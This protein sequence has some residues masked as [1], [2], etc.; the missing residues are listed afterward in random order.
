MNDRLE[1]P[2]SYGS[3]TPVHACLSGLSSEKGLAHACAGVG[4]DRLRAARR[5]NLLGR[6][7]DALSRGDGAFPTIGLWAALGLFGILASSVMV[8]VFADQ[9]AHRRHL[10]AMADAFE[11][12]ITLPQG[13]HGQPRLRRRRPLPPTRYGFLFWL[14]LG[15]LREQVT[16]VAGVLM[17]VPT[18]ISMDPYGCGTKVL[19]VAYIAMNALVMRKTKAGQA[20]VERYNSAVYGRVGDHRQRYRR[21]KLCAAACETDAMRSVMSDP[22]GCAVSRADVV[23]HPDRSP[24]RRRRSRWSPCS[25]LAL[26]SRAAENSRLARSSRSW[27]LRAFDCEARSDL[28]LRHRNASARARSCAPLR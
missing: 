6:V 19:A 7:V 27:A 28:R 4:R 8:A 11:R 15:A 16:A 23:G 3:R 22:P 13:Y 2:H 12:A 25:Q 1:R 14:W 20:N 18:A 24:A 9:L 21:A 10:A 17:L 26:C 5:A